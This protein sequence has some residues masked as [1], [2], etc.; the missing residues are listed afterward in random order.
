MGIIDVLEDQIIFEFTGRVN[1]LKKG[2]NQY[3]GRLLLKDGKI[4]SCEY[5]KVGGLKSF[6]NLIVDEEKLDIHF[7]IE[8]EVV[9]SSDR[10]LDENISFPEL[11]EKLNLYLA[12]YKKSLKLKP[13]P[14]LKLSINPN[15]LKKGEEISAKEFDILCVISDYSRAEDIYRSANLADF[16]ITNALVTLRKK[17]ALLVLK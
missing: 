14:D 7:I 12:E 16:E 17:N 2:N 9:N 11:K 1:V 13:P 4:I 15:F 5:D 10:N 8:P 3:L 6:Y